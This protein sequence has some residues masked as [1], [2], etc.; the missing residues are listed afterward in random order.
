MAIFDSRKPRRDSPLAL[1]TETIFAP[2]QT[3][4]SPRTTGFRAL[5]PRSRV[6]LPE[7]DRP[8]KTRIS[9]SATVSEQSCTPKICPVL[10]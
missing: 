2:S 7:P 9:P 6:D 3:R 10:V 4:I 8:I 5:T 1:V